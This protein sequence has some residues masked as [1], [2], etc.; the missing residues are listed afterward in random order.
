MR[1]RRP[2]AGYATR[3][4]A[5]DVQCLPDS[6]GPRLVEAAAIPETFFTVWTNVFERGR[7]ARGGDGCS[8]TA[9]RA[10]SA[11]PRFSWPSARGARVTGDRR[12]RREVR[13]VRAARC[14][15][16]PGNYR[17]SDWVAAVRDATGGQG[18]NLVLDMVGGDYTARNLDALAVEGRLMQIAFLKSPRVELDLVVAD[19]AAPVDHRVD[20]PGRARPPRRARLPARS[21]R[22]SGRSSRNDA[23]PRS[24]TRY[25]PSR[26]PPTPIGGWSP[27]PTSGKIVLDVRA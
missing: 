15:R 1:A 27:A 22:A 25:F 26:R 7:L 16:T 6:R 3:C 8:C 13:R 18:A 14:R 5:P 2:A 21:S 12:Q 11:R 17:T 10:A 24:S 20:A 4:V 23:W 19:A 9:A